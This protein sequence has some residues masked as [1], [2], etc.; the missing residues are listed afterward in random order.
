MEMHLESLAAQTVRLTALDLEVDFAAGERI[1]TE[2]SYKYAPGQVEA[3]L[4]AAGFAPE[5]TWTDA[6]NWFAVYLARV[7]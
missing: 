6:R 1:H 7:L 5:S 3:M 2:N 4:T